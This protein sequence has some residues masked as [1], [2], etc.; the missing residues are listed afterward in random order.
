VNILRKRRWFSFRPK[1]PGFR[2]RN[3]LGEQAT[4]RLAAIVTSSSDAIIGKT[5]DGTVTSWNEAAS[6][7]FGYSEEEMIGAN[8]RRLIPQERQEE[9]ASILGHIAAGRAIKHYETARLH[10]DG[11][12]LRVCVSV[13][14][15]RD[16]SGTIIGASKIVH[17][18]GAEKLAEENLRDS[19]ARYRAIVETALDAIII[20]DEAGQ[21]QSVNP[22][23]ERLLG[24]SPAELVGRNVSIIMPDPHRSAHDGYLSAYLKTGNAKIIGIGREVQPQRKDGSLFPAELAVTEWKAR[25]QNIA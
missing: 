7:L 11:R 19:E 9:E 24:Y 10:K 22:A 23:C 21:I 17:D 14:P 20:I 3:G 12:L 16:A 4:A 1:L 18:I 5:I 8:I 13:S 6:Q 2:S 25:G 15:I